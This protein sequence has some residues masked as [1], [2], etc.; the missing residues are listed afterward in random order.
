GGGGNNILNNN[1]ASAIAGGSANT[2][3]ANVANGFIGGGYENNASGSFSTVPGGQ[4]NFAG[5]TFSFAAGQ[6]AQAFHEGAFVWADSQNATFSSTANDQFLIRA[7]GGVGIGTP[8][9]AAMLHVFSTNQ[10]QLEVEGV[11]HTP[12]AIRLGEAGF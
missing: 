3:G 5:G 9:P 10:F 11:G 2:I 12:P 6:Q 7:Q 4:L 8:N 1:S